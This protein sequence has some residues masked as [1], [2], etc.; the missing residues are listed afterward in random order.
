MF[1]QTIKTIIKKTQ[2]THDIVIMLV[3]CFLLGLS[4][5]QFLD[6][7]GIAPGGVTGL[8]IILNNLTRIPVWAINLVFNIPLFI[9]AIK[10]LKGE[11]SKTFLGIAFLTIFLKV[12]PITTVTNDVLLSAIFGG[13]TMGVGLGL[14]FRV[15][16]STG[17]TDLLALLINNFFSVN[18]PAQADRHC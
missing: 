13:I 5:N 1:K 7:H 12:L 14:I 2:K 16:G 6:P 18:E 3:G 11:A 8:A 4:V 17:G 9:C 15:N 10:L